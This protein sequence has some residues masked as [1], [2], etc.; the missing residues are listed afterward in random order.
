[1]SWELYEVWSVDE[2]NHESLIDTTQ[3]LK[4]AQEIASATLSE[5]DSVIEIII[6]KENDEGDLEEIERFPGP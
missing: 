2:D 1:M 3:S 5:D 6:Y 4:E